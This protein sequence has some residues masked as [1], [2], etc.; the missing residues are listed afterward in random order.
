MHHA[1][2]D[3]SSMTSSFGI[4]IFLIKGPKSTPLEVKDIAAWPLPEDKLAESRNRHAPKVQ[5]LRVGVYSLAHMSKS[6]IISE[7]MKG[8]VGEGKY[9]NS[10]PGSEELTTCRRMMPLDCRHSRVVSTPYLSII[11]DSSQL[12]LRKDSANK[13]QSLDHR[14]ISIAYPRRFI[15]DI[16]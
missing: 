13:V 14:R 6:G 15:G 5:K 10:Q 8:C 7:E 9:F 12:S 11:N 16:I 3:D 4:D 1:I 2:L